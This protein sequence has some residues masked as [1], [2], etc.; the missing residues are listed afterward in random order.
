MN[1]I[2]I[3]GI[4]WKIIKIHSSC[5]YWIPINGISWRIRKKSYQFMLVFHHHVFSPLDFRIAASRQALAGEEVDPLLPATEVDA[6]D[7]DHWWPHWGPGASRDGGTISKRLCWFMLVLFEPWFFLYLGT[8]LGI[9]YKYYSY[10]SHGD[11][12]KWM[13]YN[14]KSIYKWMI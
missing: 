11:T 3:N 7:G 2:P 13:V 1:W 10:D 14:G 6:G 4:S 9:L 12:Q 8:Y 5:W